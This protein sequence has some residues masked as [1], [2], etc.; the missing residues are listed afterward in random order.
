MQAGDGDTLNLAA[1][2]PVRG[3]GPRCCGDCCWRC[4]QRILS[5]RLASF[6][7]HTCRLSFASAIA[8]WSRSCSRDCWT[9]A[10]SNK[11]LLFSKGFSNSVLVLCQLGR[12][13]GHLQECLLKIFRLSSDFGWQASTIWS[14]EEP[15]VSLM[16][17]SMPMA[18]SAGAG[19]GVVSL[20]H[21]PIDVRTSFCSE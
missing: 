10:S 1:R 3:C 5:H 2:S 13:S 18:R 14:T 11:R 19:G 9:C 4:L 12:K 21:A 16:H 7:W 15:G 20:P 17:F 8:S 6:C